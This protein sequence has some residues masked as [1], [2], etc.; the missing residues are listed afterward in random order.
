MEEEIWLPLEDIRARGRTT[1]ARS[2]RIDWPA[3]DGARGTCPAPEARKA[4]TAD[5]LN[6]TAADALLE[7]AIFVTSIEKRNRIM[8]MR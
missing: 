2:E 4:D 7:V 8:K 6:R 1:A 3:A 5:L